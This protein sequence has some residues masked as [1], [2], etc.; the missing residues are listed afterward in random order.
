ML[1][2]LKAMA[3]KPHKMMHAMIKGFLPGK[4]DGGI[5]TL[6]ADFI[7]GPDCKIIK[8]HYGADISDHIPVKDIIKTLD[9]I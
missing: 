4:I 9:E 8:A 1:G 3:L 5:S 2:V 6:P 7:I